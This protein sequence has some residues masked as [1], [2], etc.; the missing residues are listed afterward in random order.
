MGTGIEDIAAHVIIAD[1]VIAARERG[2][3]RRIGIG[4]GSSHS[5]GLWCAEV[6]VVH[7][8]AFVQSGEAAAEQA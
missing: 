5:G 7:R 2:A 6:S 1:H 8:D 3:G 4:R